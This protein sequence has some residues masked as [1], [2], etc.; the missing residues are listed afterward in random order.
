[1]IHQVAECVYWTILGVDKNRLAG[2]FVEEKQDV[3]ALVSIEI[4]ND[5][6]FVECSNVH[7]RLEGCS[8]V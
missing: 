2:F 7:L 1:M 8:G 3:A 5:V 4:A 6:D